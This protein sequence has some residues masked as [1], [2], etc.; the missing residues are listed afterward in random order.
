MAIFERT[1]QKEGSFCR[2]EIGGPMGATDAAFRMRRQSPLCFLMRTIIILWVTAPSKERRPMIDKTAFRSLSYGLYLVA[3]TDGER[4][5]ACVANTF[6]QVTSSPLQVSV[7]LNKENAT[8]GVI[9]DSGRFAV[10]CLAQDA[11]M[12]LIGMFRLSVQPRCRQ[13]GLVRDGRRWRGR[14]FRFRA[15]RR[16]V[17]RARGADGGPRHARSLRRRGGGGRGAARRRADDLRALPPREGRQ[18]PAEGVEL[19]ARGALRGRGRRC[20]RE[21]V[22]ADE[23]EVRLALHAVRPHRVRRRAARRLRLPVCGVGKDMFERIE[24]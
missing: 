5:A 9:A 23:A 20:G 15:V 17:L 1:C 12:E 21:C 8:T 2:N 6:Q 24:L 10:S 13:A 22:G 16:A 14:S 4:R 19:P 11:A 3:A 18:D 7:A